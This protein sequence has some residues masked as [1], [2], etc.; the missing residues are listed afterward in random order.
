[1]LKAKGDL[2]LRVVI[3]AVKVGYLFILGLATFIGTLTAIET[4]AIRDPSFKS[5]RAIDGHWMER[6]ASEYVKDRIDEAPMRSLELSGS[7][8]AWGFLAAILIPSLLVSKALKRYS[9]NTALFCG[10]LGGGIGF[11]LGI[12]AWTPTMLASAGMV[13]GSAF[14][15]FQSASKWF[16]H[17]VPL[18]LATFFIWAHSQ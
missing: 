16:Y 13:I 14:A 5:F 4:T 9:M 6:S 7:P 2:V 10:L 17:L 1:M 8:Y 12:V 11:I 15:L 18:A 3:S